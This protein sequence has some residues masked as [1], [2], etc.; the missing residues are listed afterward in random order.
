[1]FFYE[2]LVCP[3]CGKAFTDDDDI[4]A[5]PKCGAAHHRECWKSLGHCAYEADHGT[6]NQWSREKAR[7]SAAE[8]KTAP[9][10]TEPPE[11]TASGWFC[12]KCGAANL[13]Y[14]EFCTRCGTER[15]NAPEWQS[16]TAPEK[17]AEPA[18]NEYTPYH[19][20]I[21]TRDPYGGVAPETEIDG[22]SAED[23]ASY[24]GNNS[25]YYL[26][27]FQSI[28]AGRRVSW[29]WSAFLFTSYWLMYRKNYLTGIITLIINA[30]YTIMFSVCSTQMETLFGLSPNGM[31]S[32]PEAYTELFYNNESFRYL[33]VCMA[34]LSLVEVALRVFLGLFG[35][36]TY[37]N[38]VCAKIQRMRHR[39]PDGYAE[40][41]PSVGGVSFVT[42]MLSYLLS[43]YLL[44]FLFMFFT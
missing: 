41:L 15:D 21:P 43:S 1:M 37:Q 16:A 32:S 33:M 34:L 22:V 39:D 8:P 27:R 28:A 26:P 44:Q 14:A 24:V 35:N 29:N 42:G 10:P 36:W 17:K 38:T 9:S 23:I 18:Y 19:I 11:A 25:H 20:H 40:T 13:E 2:G 4:V 7:Q 5:C 6:P 12:P 3:V 31:L 30:L